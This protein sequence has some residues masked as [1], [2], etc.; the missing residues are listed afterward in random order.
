MTESILHVWAAA[1][2]VFD[3]DMWLE[4]YDVDAEPVIEE[5]IVFADGILINGVWGGRIWLTANRD[6]A[7]RFAS[8]ADALEAWNIVSKTR[9]T[10]PD[11]L[12]NK[13]LTA[14]SIHVEPARLS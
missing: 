7:H 11:G 13:P 5:S 1:D 14:L 10:R 2:H 12:P 9:P 6:E 4:K 8:A 3:R